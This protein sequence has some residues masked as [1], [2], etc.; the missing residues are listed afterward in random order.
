MPLLLLDELEKKNLVST[1]KA[2]RIRNAYWYRK[3]KHLGWVEAPKEERERKP[4]IK[5]K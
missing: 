1:D 2:N 4:L 5:V 3:R